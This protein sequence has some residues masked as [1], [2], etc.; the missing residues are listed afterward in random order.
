MIRKIL[1]KLGKVAREAENGKEKDIGKLYVFLFGGSAIF[2]FCFLSIF[3][4]FAKPNDNVIIV[5]TAVIFTL[6]LVVC[7]VAREKF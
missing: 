5:S 3:S 1:A 2:E 7:A 6:L 4:R